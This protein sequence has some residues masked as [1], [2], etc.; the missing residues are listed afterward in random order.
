M[1]RLEKALDS[2]IDSLAE[3]YKAIVLEIFFVMGKIATGMVFSF[4]FLFFLLFLLLVA[5]CLTCVV[6]VLGGGAFCHT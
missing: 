4:Y 2:I 5:F 6:R 1:G 3:L